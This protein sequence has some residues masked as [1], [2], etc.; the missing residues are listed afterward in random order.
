MTLDALV[1]KYLEAAG[2]FGRRVH[3]S[4]LGPSKSETEKAIAALDEDY[5]I[6]RY[7]S[8]SREGEEALSAIPADCRFFRIN[9]F[10]VT[11]LII[12]AGI[13]KLL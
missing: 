2:S 9:G 10:E 6:S 4:R 7:L 3:L 11:H 12:D 13:Q 1:G 5:Q 8:L